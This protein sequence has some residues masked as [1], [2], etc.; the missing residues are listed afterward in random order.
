MREGGGEYYVY[1]YVVSAFF[2]FSFLFCFGVVNLYH[3]QVGEKKK[4]VQRREKI[5]NV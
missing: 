1:V 4:G 3:D 2:F 5:D